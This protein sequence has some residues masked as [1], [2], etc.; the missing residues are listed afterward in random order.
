MKFS[1]FYACMSSLLSSCCVWISEN[2]AQI[3]LVYVHLVGMFQFFHPVFYSEILSPPWFSLLMNPMFGLLYFSFLVFQPCF[4]FWIPFSY[5]ALSSSIHS[6]VCLYSLGIQLR[7]HLLFFDFFEHTHNHFLS[8][9]PE[10]FSNSLSILLLEAFTVR[11]VV[12]MARIRNV[13]Q[14]LIYLRTWSPGGGAVWQQ[15]WNL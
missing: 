12:V 3:W 6:A 5:V 10:F 13:P 2:P 11:L 1:F 8:S 9:L 14:R 4:F 7:I 15:L